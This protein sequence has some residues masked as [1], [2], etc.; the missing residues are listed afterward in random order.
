[1]KQRKEKNVDTK[2][3]KVSKRS[4][5]NS[6]CIVF[7]TICVLVSVSAFV[8][9]KDILSDDVMND[10]L[11]RL[12]SENSSRVYDRNGEVIRTLSGKSGVRESISYDEIPQVVIDAFLAVEDSRYFK[13]SGFDLPRFVKSG[14]EN[15]L[16]GGVVQ[17]GSTLTMQLI[18]VQLFDEDVKATFGMKEKLE[19]KIIEIFKSMDIESQLDKEKIIEHYLNAINFGGQARG[20]EKGSEYYFNKSVKNLTL[21]E[22]AFLAGVINAPGAYNPYG[23]GVVGIDYYA[24][25]TTRRNQVLYQMHNHGYISDE[26]YESARATDLAYQLTGIK[27]FD[28]EKHSG[29][30]DAVIAEVIEKTGENPYITPMDIYTT[31]DLEAQEL[32]DALSDGKDSD[33]NVIFEYP[34][35][36]FQSGFAAIDNQTGE[37]LALGAGRG[38]SAAGTQKQNRAT[39]DVHQPGSTAKPIFDYAPAFEELGYSTEHV[40]EDGP[41]NYPDEHHTMYNYDKKFRGDVTIKEAVGKSLNIPAYKT[42]S[43][44]QQK[45]GTDGILDYF[46]NYGFENL[47]EEDIN[48]S[49]S[50]GG[51]SLSLTPLQLASAY[52]TM[53]NEGERMEPH[54]VKKVVF[55]DKEKK[56]YEAEVEKTK[57]FSPETAYLTSVLLKDAVDTNYYTLVNT[58]KGNYPIYGKSGTTD[59][60]AVSAAN[61]GV[62]EGA[63][64]DKWMV[65]YTNKFTVACWAGWDEGTKGKYLTED[66]ISLNIE[67]RVVKHMLDNLTKYGADAD[68]IPKPS[69][70]VNISHIQGLFPYATASNKD[71]S[72]MVNALINKKFAKLNSVAPDTLEELNSFDASLSNNILNLSFAA[73]PDESLLKP[74]NN[75]KTMSAGG[76]TIKGLQMFSKTKLFG[77]VRYFYEVFVNDVPVLSNSSDKT[78]ITETLNTRENDNVRVCGYYGYSNA[79]LT[80]AK[81]CRNLISTNVSQ[82]F[83]I[84]SDFRSLFG[85]NASNVKAALRQY[86]EE[87]LPGINVY[88]LDDASTPEG[89][90]SHKS[91]I[92][93]GDIVS[94]DETYIIYVGTKK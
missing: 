65:A 94:S 23:S 47:R 15:V 67:G 8:V 49:L 90:Y 1:M 64:K 10:N 21:T 84:G 62:P 54:T 7:L 88:I 52:S 92:D 18:D 70:V 34:D 22:A 14:Y 24:Q 35:E 13:H 51:G 20:I 89:E 36:L 29:F 68:A 86:V 6:I 28:T 41:V 78:Q 30:I 58:L 59:Y 43:A 32:A 71:G 26:E 4:I 85:G 27:N 48:A 69:G 66:L 60:D 5:V 74:F 91:T 81:Q 73:Y 75:E 57:V 76:V 61:A 39:I 3:K 33:G 83:R 37:I 77:T 25:A 38:Y 16:H 42:W 79:S 45:I 17:G 72:A 46:H 53:A 9:V 31:M 12:V 44:V 2:K 55:Q 63:A 82:S 19:Q 56:N 11:K 87:K 80:S 40:I 93:V 50:I